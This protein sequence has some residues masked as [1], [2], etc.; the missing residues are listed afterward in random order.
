MQSRKSEIGTLSAKKAR[1]LY[2]VTKEHT[3]NV[4]EKK[5]RN[6]V[7]PRKSSIEN[8]PANKTEKSVCSLESVL[9]LVENVYLRTR[10]ETFRRL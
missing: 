5:T 6:C 1:N 3:E 2:A 8:L 10:R 7:Q 4:T 9:I